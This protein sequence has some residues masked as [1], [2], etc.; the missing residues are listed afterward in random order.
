MEKSLAELLTHFLRSLSIKEFV[1]ELRGAKLRRLQEALEEKR[2]CPAARELIEEELTAT[3]A[4]EAIG[5]YANRVKRELLR[6][7]IRQSD[8]ELIQSEV[9]LASPRLVVRK[10]KVVPDF[11]ASKKLAHHASAVWCLSVMAFGAVVLL[12]PPFLLA[13]GLNMGAGGGL[14][15]IVFGLFV[16]L[17]GAFLMRESEP[18]RAAYRIAS[19]LEELQRD[20]PASPSEQLAEKSPQASAP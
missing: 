14:V 15:L 7:L 18:R 16:V 1:R 6:D 3:H 20:R 2:L 4:R 9:T 10:R 13:F 11:D 17:F 5:L 19:L 12:A 8:G